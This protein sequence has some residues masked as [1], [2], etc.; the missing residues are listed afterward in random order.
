MDIALGVVFLV[1]GVLAVFK[2]KLLYSAESLSAERA[3]RNER[4]LKRL[5]ILL[6]VLGIADLAVQAFRLLWKR[7]SN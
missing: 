3:A 7:L 6:T 1:I 5:G 4:I 2:P